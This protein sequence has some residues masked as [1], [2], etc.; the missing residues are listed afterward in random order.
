MS[1]ENVQP[2]PSLADE[3]NTAMDEAGWENNTQSESAPVE[4]GSRSFADDMA[5]YLDG[6]HTE[7]PTSEPAKSEELPVHV[8]VPATEPAKQELTLG[9]QFLNQRKNELEIERLQ[10]ENAELLGTKEK[11]G[12][13]PTIDERNFS[14]HELKKLAK[15]NPEEFMKLSGQSMD[16]Y[17]DYSAQYWAND[18]KLPD[19]VRE[20]MRDNEIKS[21]RQEMNDRDE[22]ASALQEQRQLEAGLNAL[23]PEVD[24]IVNIDDGQFPLVRAMDEANSVITLIKD[25]YMQSHAEGNPRLLTVEE[26]SSMVEEELKKKY[27]PIL[28]LNR[29]KEQ[30]TVR[31]QPSSGERNGDRTERVLPLTLAQEQQ[32]NA[33]K[34]GID[35]DEAFRSDMEAFLKSNGI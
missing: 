23:K 19:D 24:A 3:F 28:N 12:Q 4:E 9:E 29:A 30:Q 18:N 5:D 8:D 6:N 2:E 25:Y 1:E 22:R 34:Q 27:A 10:R 33:M 16:D 11:L 21:L 20:Q 13:E 15:E 32:S 17:L 14:V 35:E 31:P 26:A 7:Q